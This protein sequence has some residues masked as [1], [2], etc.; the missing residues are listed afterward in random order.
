MQSAWSEGA[1]VE[2]VETGAP[3][4][5]ARWIGRWLAPAELP[6]VVLV[7]AVALVVAGSTVAMDWVKGSEIL[8]G[9]TALG[10]LLMSALALVRVVPALVA[11]PAGLAGS[12]LVPYYVNQA[13]LKAAHPGQPLGIPSPGDW[14]QALSGS[15][16]NIDGSFFLLTACIVMFAAGAWLAW[17]TV[18]WRKPLLGLFP[19]AAVFATNVLNSTD[20]Q[21]ANVI[22]F[23]VLTIALLL[24]SGYRANLVSA[25][26]SGLR[27]S[28][29]SR[30]DFWETGVAATAGVM[31]LAIFLPPLTHDDQTVNVENGVFRN[32]AEFQ[33][34]L[35]HPVEIGRGGAATFSTGFSL[36]AGLNGALKKSDK[37]VFEYTYTGTYSGPRYFRGVNLQ[38]G[39]RPNQWAFLNNPFGYQFFVSRNS[40]VPYLD[41]GLTEQFSSTV[42]VHMLRPPAIAPDVIFYPGELLRSDRDTVAVE[43]YKTAADPIFGSVDRVSSSHPASSA[44]FYKVTVQYPNPTQ[45]QLRNAGADYPA[46]IAPYLAYPGLTGTPAFA[47]TGTGRPGQSTNTIQIVPATTDSTS[48]TAQLIKALADQV[49]AGATDNYDKAAAIESYLRGNYVYTLTP[50]PPKDASTD[51]LKSFLFDSKQGY[52]EY[53]ATAM[54]DM[55][56]AEGIP[57][58]LVNGYGPGSYDSKLKQYVVRESDAHTWVEAY[59]PNFGWIPFEP[60]PDGSYF[61]IPRAAQPAI[62]NRDSCQVAGEDT[63]PTGVPSEGGKTRINDLPGG[64]VPDQAGPL[65]SQRGF[66]YWVFIPVAL[67]L[68]AALA[69][70]LL[71]RFLRPR[72]AALVWRRIGFLSRLAGHRGPPGETPLE[73]GRRL[74]N[75]F[76]EA[77]RP[78]QELSASFAVAAY[79]P[80]D[81]AQARAAEVVEGWQKVR[82]HLVRRV[83]ARFTPAF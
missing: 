66:P 51:P 58:R 62:C 74:A 63:G 8:P 71:G 49:T 5:L 13:A 64:D 55:L 78:L 35:N 19:G 2:N 39:V 10:V 15:D 73:T 43:S 18:R 67:L 44:G 17:C 30:W 52:C 72:T 65:G 21:N 32:W 33:Q 50:P 75:T 76:P 53:F 69:F 4:R 60:T 82:P 70:I 83:V 24:W 77:A 81:A 56:R 29:D 34:N 68:A 80:A 25:L 3:A 38:N 45:D 37:V 46:W 14:I 11:L 27:L 61:P 41:Q 31:L 42:T 20:E 22:Y 47:S 59:F 6:T 36:D 12:V 7:L 28:S 40:T 57:A 9:M 48:P 1:A 54:G 79:A 26:R 23:L 16:S